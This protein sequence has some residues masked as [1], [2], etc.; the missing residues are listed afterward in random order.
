[1][2]PKIDTLV[3][4]ASINDWVMYIE[5]YRLNSSFAY[6]KVDSALS[7]KYKAQLLQIY[8]SEY[9]QAWLRFLSSISVREFTSKCDGFIIF[10]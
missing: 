6:Q 2:Q 7:N 4:S 9:A 1:M 10:L 3:H 5:P 8:F